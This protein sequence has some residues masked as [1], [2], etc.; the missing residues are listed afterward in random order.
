[1]KAKLGMKA[2]GGLTKIN[3]TSDGKRE[4]F[5]YNILTG[6]YDPYPK[7]DIPFIPQAKKLI[8]ES[9]YKGAMDIL[10]TAKGLEADLAR[11]FYLKIYQ[12]FPFDSR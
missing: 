12:L 3:K 5:V 4:K 11:I 10:K 2:K 6:A 9:N 7:F 1:M 8:Q